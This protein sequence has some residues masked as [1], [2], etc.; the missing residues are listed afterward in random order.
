MMTPNL[1]LTQELGEYD[2]IQL[3]FDMN[4]S[5]TELSEQMGTSYSTA[6]KWSQGRRNPCSMARRLAWFIKNQESISA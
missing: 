3:R 5:L 1:Q 2:P 6:S 4:W